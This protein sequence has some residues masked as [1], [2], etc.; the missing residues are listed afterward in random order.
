[1]SAYTC[2]RACS[3]DQSEQ[4]RTIKVD[5]RHRG[6]GLERV[7]QVLGTGGADAIVCGVEHS[8]EHGKCV[9][10]RMTKR[11]DMGN[12]PDAPAL[13]TMCAQPKSA[14]ETRVHVRLHAAAP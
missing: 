6:V 12:Q 2:P 10:R 11:S 8:A 9:R 14:R 7:G 1:M 4:S 3:A 5:L 13:E